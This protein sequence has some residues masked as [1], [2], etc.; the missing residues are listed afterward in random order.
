MSRNFLHTKHIAVDINGIIYRTV[1]DYFQRV[2]HLIT[3]ILLSFYAHILKQISYVPVTVIG[4]TIYAKLIAATLHRQDINYRLC[5][6]NNRLITYETSQGKLIQFEGPTHMTSNE[7][8]PVLTCNED[9][10]DKLQEHTGL[11]NVA[12]A[13]QN[14]LNTMDRVGGVYMTS[15][16]DLIEHISYD[17]TILSMEKIS[18]N[19]FYIS[20]PHH[21]W[22]TRLIL[23]D[24]TEPLR[25]GD[26]ITGF[27]VQSAVQSTDDTR[28]SNV[29]T[30]E[31]TN[32]KLAMQRRSLYYVED[33][34]DITAYPRPKSE[35]SLLYSLREA[36]PFTSGSLCI[37]HPFHLPIGWDPLLPIM[38]ITLA[39]YY[40]L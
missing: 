4:H 5:K 31:T 9:E 33:N 18:A 32:D 13:Q 10:L 7:Q 35:E 23:S 26:T 28:S 15:L 37:I 24:M 21:T 34:L 17:D 36:R 6:T 40:R 30:V 8:L 3:I 27:I 20:T 16:D 29:I 1:P 12:Q 2:L 25:A 38:I 22:Y 14:I 19:L 11:T 39:V